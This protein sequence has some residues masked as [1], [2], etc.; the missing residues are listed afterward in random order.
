MSFYMYI[1]LTD[2]PGYCGAD[3]ACSDDLRQEWCWLWG[4]SE[5]GELPFSYQ[6]LPNSNVLV[7]LT[8]WWIRESYKEQK[9]LHV[10]CSR[11]FHAGTCSL[12]RF[13]LIAWRFYG[14]SINL[15]FSSSQLME[16]TGKNQD[17]CMVALHDCNEDVSRAINFLLECTSDMVNNTLR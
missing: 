7:A 4:Q 8:T 17:E 12:S 15:M 16:V 1:L 5:P 13:A 10:M 2:S 14:N 9:W 6:L 11:Q 3:P